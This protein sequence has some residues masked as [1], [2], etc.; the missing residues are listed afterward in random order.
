MSERAKY[1]A[2]KKKLEGIC[3][4]NNLVFSFNHNRYPITLTIRPVSGLDAQL[5]ML[6]SVEEDGYISPEA[7]IVF[8][9]KDGALSYKTSETVTISDALF[10]K[11]KNLF[12]NLHFTWLQYFFRDICERKLLTEQNM[13]VISE[14]EA[15]EEDADTL[16]ISNDADF[17]DVDDL[18]ETDLEEMDADRIRCAT[19]IVRQENKASISLL[20]RTM[21]IGYSQAARI[22]DALEE[23]GVVGPFNGSSP[24]EVLMFDAPDDTE[25]VADAE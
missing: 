3:E 7:T 6:E 20:Q 18:E 23:D 11:L 25:I 16:D 5:S 1:E 9:Y 22:M 8:A 24:R 19:Q 21:N 13:P 10:S 4:E 17:E 2:Y 15:D 12:K 14:A